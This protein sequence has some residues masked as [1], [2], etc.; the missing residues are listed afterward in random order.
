MTRLR[1][2][3][4]VAAAATA[5]ASVLFATA[6]LPAAA[7][8]IAFSTP[9]VVDPIHTFGEPDLGIDPLGRVFVSGPTGTGTQRSM[10]EGSVDGGKSFREVSAGPPPTPLLGTEQPP[11]G[12][13][14]ELKFDHNARQYFADLYALACLRVA[15]TGDG[16]ATVQNGIAG[17]CETTGP[18]ADRQWLSVFDPVGVK[19]TSPYTGP[20][21]L[22]YL[23]YNDLGLVAGSNYPNGGAQWNKSTDGLNYTQ[24]IAGNPPVLGQAAPYAPFGADGY[25]AIDQVTGDVFEASGFQN[26]DGTWSLLLNVGTPDSTGALTFLDQGNTD[27][28]QLPNLLIHIADGL[29]GSPDVLFSVLS[30]D[31]SRNLYA[32]FAVSADASHPGQRQTYVSAASAA[33]GWRTWTRPVQVSKAPS[34]VAV[35][36]W[37]KA[38]GAGRADAV[39][40]GGNQTADPSTT[41]SMVWDVFM[42]QLVFPVNKS[43]AITGAAPSVTMVKATPHPMHFGTICL[44]GTNCITIQ[45]NRNLA[46]FFEVTA[47][48]TGA[49]EIVYDDTSNGLV[50][51]GFTPDNQQ[52]VDHAGAPL[53]TIL[54]QSS[55]LGLL[56]TQ[57]SGTSNSV[58]SGLTDASGDALFPV[59][60][61]AGLPGMDITSVTTSLSSGTLT[62][63][64]KVADLSTPA[65]ALAALPGATNL[66]YVVRWQMGNT[67]Y[68]AAME[69]TA[70]NQPVF[71][72]GAARSVDLCSVSACFP[73]VLTFPE[74]AF[75]GA[76]EAGSIS[77]PSA[78]SASN[79]CT[80]TIQVRAGD[81]GT[82]V[83]SSVLEEVGGYSF[84]AT[85]Q[86]GEITNAQAFADNVPIEIDGACCFN[87]K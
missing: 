75:G 14:T 3:A 36:P 6:P 62:V 34:M 50:Q 85:T 60:G 44:I 21:P 74:P 29:S 25:P 53:V 57:V 10:W 18:G 39:W 8:G 19:S 78:P 26:A 5:V 84:A 41:T 31:S 49:A 46:D 47:D 58:R 59:N 2:T 22:I 17:G 72:A 4:F 63:T 77:C 23:D 65:T 66:Q 16:G 32:A 28:S 86:S 81:V 67:I 12:G 15:T 40:Y 69:N 38:G 68:Y 61:G 87:G 9:T 43:G 27:A 37:I 33:S 64:L 51:P 73:H 30:M 56:G 55:G 83:N 7:S 35:M 52:L 48:S 70:A 80:L 54:R 13:D 79:P 11:G 71:Y 82:P 45:G 20:L 76:A 1:R 24:A 42:S